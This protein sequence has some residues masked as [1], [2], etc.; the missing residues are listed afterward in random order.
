MLFT[1]LMQCY[2]RGLNLEFQGDL[3]F[4]YDIFNSLNIVYI[5][6]QLHSFVLL[7]THTYIRFMKI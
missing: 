4:S 1:G 6:P 5:V 7:L 3:K 2:N